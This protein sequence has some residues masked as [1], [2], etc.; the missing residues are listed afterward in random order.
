VGKD[1]PRSQLITAALPHF[2]FLNPLAINN[3][4]MVPQQALSTV[5]NIDDIEE[6]IAFNEK[7]NKKSYLEVIDLPISERPQIMQE[8]SLMGITGG[9]MFPG[10]DGAREQLREKNFNI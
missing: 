7:N 8:L 6:F 3:L 10:L 2:S 9:S 1:V 4:R 5:A